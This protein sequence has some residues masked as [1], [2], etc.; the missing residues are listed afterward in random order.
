M[1]N[2]MINCFICGSWVKPNKQGIYKCPKCKAK[3]K[4][5][6]EG[7]IIR[8]YENSEVENEQL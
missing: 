8:I 4:K 1:T 7:Q 2:K 6:N 3:Y 5:T